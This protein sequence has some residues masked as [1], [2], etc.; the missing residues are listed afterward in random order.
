LG[1]F[2]SIL[3][4]LT[5][6][7]LSGDPEIS[8]SDQVV[9]RECQGKVPVD[10][11]DSPM[12][13]FPEIADGLDPAKR[14][15]NPFAD[16]KTD[17]V[18]IMPGCTAIYGRTTFSGDVL[19]YMGCRFEASQVLDKVFRVVALVAADGNPL[20]TGDLSH[21]LGCGFPLCRAGGMGDGTIYDK[22][23]SVLHQ[24][25]TQVTHP[26]FLA[27]AFLVE[28]GIGVGSGAMGIV[29]ERFTM[30]VPLLVPSLAASDHPWAGSS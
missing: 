30:K 8:H 23:V 19:G 17:A 13:G 3:D 15:F 14:L 4:A 27:G 5:P 16:A 26:G 10:L 29:L 12:S 6:V 18:A 11:S 25:M 7:L 24:G 1:R 22:A 20:I 2:L 9:C 21:H 28:P